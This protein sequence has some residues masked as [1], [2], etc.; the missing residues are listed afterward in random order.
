M[1]N[2]YTAAPADVNDSP[3][4][5]PVQ[6]PN[7]G[8]RGAIDDAWGRPGP[9]APGTPSENISPARTTDTSADT[10]NAILGH[11]EIVV[12][13]TVQQQTQLLE[14]TANSAFS[15]EL[16]RQSNEIM[17]GTIVG[18]IN[19]A[20]NVLKTGIDIAS[21]DPVYHAEKFAQD[22]LEYEFGNPANQAIAANNVREDLANLAS[23]SDKA[24]QALAKG[25]EPV[26]QH[27]MHVGDK[28]DH[29]PMDP[30]VYAQLTADSLNFAVQVINDF[31][32]QAPGKQAHDFMENLT[33]F[34][35][36]DGIGHAASAASGGLK[37]AQLLEKA[38]EKLKSAESLLPQ[39]LEPAA[40]GVVF[41][42]YVFN[43]EKDQ[44]TAPKAAERLNM[45]PKELKEL[46]DKQLEALGV[47]KVEEYRK[48][49]FQG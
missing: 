3:A 23:D 38:A 47:Q 37:E 30:R 18:A 4:Q 25:Y 39:T 10:A 31:S 11:V 49:F 17:N 44:L 20:F 32:N 46:D 9:A 22:Y 16:D 28:Y 27:L 29:N 24:Q 13:A 45:K 48:T 26:D 40:D 2:G 5:Q 6:Q 12:P 21:S 7:E 43:G 36:T 33:Q 35:L 34:I 19:G 15:A 42:K 1:G 41:K 14:S 8:I